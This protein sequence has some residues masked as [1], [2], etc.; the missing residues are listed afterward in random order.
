MRRR[1]LV[2]RSN[3]HGM[4]DRRDKGGMRQRA[5][6]T[7]V[8]QHQRNYSG[9]EEEASSELPRRRGRVDFGWFP[10][11]RDI[12]NWYTSFCGC[13]NLF[14]ASLCS[15]QGDAVSSGDL[16]PQAATVERPR[17]SRGNRHTHSARRAS[18]Q[19]C[20]DDGYAT[21]QLRYNK[22]RI[23]RS[24]ERRGD[25]YSSRPARVFLGSAS[26]LTSNGE[27]DTW[28]PNA[29]GEIDIERSSKKNGAGLASNAIEENSGRLEELL[30]KLSSKAFCSSFHQ[31]RAICPI[32]SASNIDE[33]D[34][35]DEDAPEGVHLCRTCR[36][37]VAASGFKLVKKMFGRPAGVDIGVQ[38][39]VPCADISVN[40]PLEMQQN[41]CRP[42]GAAERIGPPVP[43]MPNVASGEPFEG[44]P[45][46]QMGVYTY[47]PNMGHGSPV[48]YNNELCMPPAAPSNIFYPYGPIPYNQQQMYYVPNAMPMVSFYVN[49]MLKLVSCSAAGLQL[50]SIPNNARIHKRLQSAATPKAVVMMRFVTTHL[51]KWLNDQVC[52]FE[53]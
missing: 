8:R 11:R 14:Y 16:A 42:V 13:N 34:S 33:C 9:Y 45:Q 18:V 21:D 32:W 20:A 6:P 4:S 38:V 17:V 49:A 3:L 28:I 29:F 7:N 23:S 12:E 31:L 2:D 44:I 25:G 48:Y 35:A 51:R 39:K 41:I 30:Q 53:Q 15:I 27:Y 36:I 46:S 22:K 5:P 26:S 50:F 1:G 19:R 24:T 10:F 40:T 52:V 43:P 47:P 37:S